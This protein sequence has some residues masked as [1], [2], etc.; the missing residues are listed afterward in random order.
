[1]SFSLLSFQ[2]PTQSWTT[3]TI[4]LRFAE[5]ILKERTLMLALGGPG[6][7]RQSIRGRRSREKSGMSKGTEAG[8]GNV[9]ASEHARTVG[10]GVEY[11]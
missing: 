5:D 10:W 4:Q 1:M 9:G 2:G 11:W 7:D 3:G 8:K 6:T